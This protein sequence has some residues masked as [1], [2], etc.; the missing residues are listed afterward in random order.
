[1]KSQNQNILLRLQLLNLNLESSKNVVWVWY[2]LWVWVWDCV[3]VGMGVGLCVF[4]WERQ[5]EGVRERKREEGKDMF[6]VL[7]PCTCFETKQVLRVVVS[8]VSLGD[9]AYKSNC[10]QFRFLAVQNGTSKSVQ[11]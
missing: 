4:D 8:W 2:W 6:K 7:E 3:C 10:Q 11:F 1:M 5:K 9:Q